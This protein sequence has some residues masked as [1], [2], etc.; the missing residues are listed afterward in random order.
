MH[1]PPGKPKV[2]AVKRQ[3]AP[4]PAAKKPVPA[5]PKAAKPVA[6]RKLAVIE[7]STIAGMAVNSEFLKEFP[8]LSS[9]GRTIK[10]EN[11]KPRG[12]GG[13]GRAAQERTAVFTAAKQ[14]LASLDSTKKRRLK[15]LLKAQQA[16]ITYMNNS[17]KVVQLTF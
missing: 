14:A 10:S 6:L 5:A 15:E 8:F 3:P 12:C 2:T 4:P 1:T 17:G 11:G 9:I 13:C 7:E 16:R